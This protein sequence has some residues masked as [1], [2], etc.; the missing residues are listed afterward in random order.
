[1]VKGASGGSKRFWVA[2]LV[3]EYPVMF[4]DTIRS[5][6]LWPDPVRDWMVTTQY[7]VRKPLC[8][9][10][11][12]ISPDT[13]THGKY[14]LHLAK[15]TFVLQKFVSNLPIRPDYKWTEILKWW[16]SYHVFYYIKTFRHS[17]KK[18]L[19]DMIDVDKENQLFGL[20]Y[21]HK[22]IFNLEYMFLLL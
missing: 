20:V 21:K 7:L 8:H 1:M 6:T 14:L 11:N 4:S 5:S 18:W 12:K 2:V 10:G 22:I 19:I 13:H 15:F 16:L 9:R 3:L 17:E